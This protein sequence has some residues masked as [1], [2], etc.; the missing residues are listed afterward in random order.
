MQV[1]ILV[2]ANAET[3]LGHWYR[4]I[5]LADYLQGRGVHTTI[6]T[7]RIPP[8]KFSY[9]LVNY[10]D[11][12]IWQ[13]PITGH[14]DWLIVD[15][16]AEPPAWIYE[17]CEAQRINVLILNGVG[18]QVGDRATLRIVQGLDDAAEYSGV[19]YIILRDNVFKAS[20]I[21]QPIIDWFVFGG[22]ADQMKLTVNFPNWQRIVFAISKK[23]WQV[24]DNHD[25]GFLFAA[26]QCERACI[27][28][29]MTALEL[30]AWGDMPI[31]VFSISEQ[32]LNF[33][34]RLE[35]AGYISAY[36]AVGLPDDKIDMAEF[37]TIPFVPT[38][39]PIDG[40]ACRRIY[41]LMKG[42]NDG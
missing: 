41:D 38:G 42:E 28:M 20:R 17:Y 29:G 14:Y 5:A 21:R 12:P 13:S 1:K 2:F 33:A 9:H 16:P 36:P 35:T 32:H 39:K 3:G 34:Q 40:Q 15:L 11:Q 10:H 7:D 27:A 4:S 22:A 18:H 24:S 25:N 23:D 6:I 31:Y 8:D 19:D 37:L 30:A 26:S